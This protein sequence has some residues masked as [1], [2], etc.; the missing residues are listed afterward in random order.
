M[1]KINLSLCYLWIK[2]NSKILWFRLILPCHTNGS[3]KDEAS[4]V[5][6]LSCNF[7]GKSALD[8]HKKHVHEEK[9][10]N[11]CDMYLSHKGPMKRW[12]SSKKGRSDKACSFQKNFDKYDDCHT[13]TPWKDETSKVWCLL[14]NFL[15]KIGDHKT[16]FIK[17]W[18]WLSHKRPM[19]RWIFYIMMFV[20]HYLGKSALVD[21]KKHV[22]WREKITISV[23]SA[24][25][26]QFAKY[27]DHSKSRFCWKYPLID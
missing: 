25:T 2:W 21:H 17:R 10:C 24:I 1:R 3:W 22:P 8:D 18:W 20:N 27:F 7:L 14:Y 26:D 12:N 16:M 19:K 13:K 23:I 9:N 11:K 4:K 6:C 5:W 15:I